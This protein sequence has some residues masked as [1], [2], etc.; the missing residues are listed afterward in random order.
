MRAH[1]R[2]RVVT[3]GIANLADVI[4]GGLRSFGTVGDEMLHVVS[5]MNGNFEM[6]KS[7][8]SVDSHRLHLYPGGGLPGSP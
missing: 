1:N 5:A 4:F 7:R 2:G 6:N 3:D 8:T